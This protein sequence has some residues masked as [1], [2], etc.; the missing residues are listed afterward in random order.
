MSGFF[1]VY[2]MGNLFLPP[3]RIE[4]GG[5]YRNA[6]IDKYATAVFLVKA[7][8]LAWMATVGIRAPLDHLCFIK[9]C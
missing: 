8:F 1:H 4:R 3:V 9:M 2:E 5:T 6:T 7:F